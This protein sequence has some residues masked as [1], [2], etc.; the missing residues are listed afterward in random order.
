MIFAIFVVSAL[1]AQSKWKLWHQKADS[2]LAARYSRVT[3]DTTYIGRP[4]SKFTVKFRVNVSGNQ[5]KSDG[6]SM[7]VSYNSKLSTA[8]R[9]TVSAGVIYRGLGISLALNPAKLGGKDKDIETNIVYTS[10]R[11]S[12]DAT[13]QASKTLSGDFESGG[14]TVH[15]DRGM[16]DMKMLTVSGYYIF[17]HRKFSYPAAFTQ[18]FIQRRSAGSLLAGASYQYNRIKSPGDPIL[19]LPKLRTFVGNIAIGA[20]YGHN[21]VTHNGKW[22][23]H[24]SALP[25][26]IIV[27]NNN[28]SVDDEKV[29]AKYHFPD[30]IFRNCLS[31]VYNISPRHFIASTTRVIFSTYSDKDS[32]VTQN[33]WHTRLCFGMRF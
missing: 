3:Y 28:I 1:S 29:K 9:M 11:V 27:N 19:G 26:V 13:Y 32:F 5:I 12:L 14:E 18:S 22:L 17:N 7:G 4:D 23:F 33:K 2:L 25:T 24:V 15:L 31:I 16:V 21:F 8:T 20:G 6:E 10:S 30:M